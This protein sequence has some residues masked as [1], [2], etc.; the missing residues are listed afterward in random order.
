[1]R[2]FRDARTAVKLLTGFSLVAVLTVVV[3]AVGFSRISS[4]DAS[5]KSM[6]VDSTTAIGYLSDAR[7]NLGDARVQG[8]LAGMTGTPAAVASAQTAWQQDTSGITAAMNSYR[9]TNM[10]G[11]ETQLAAFD[12]AYADYLSNAP[13]LWDLALAHDQA[14]FEKFRRAM[15]QPSAT[16]ATVALTALSMIENTDAKAAADAGHA[17]AATAELLMIAIA[18]ATAL[19]SLTLALL[20]GRMISRPLQATVAVLE[21]VARGELN[22]VVE[23]T[24]NDEIGRMRAALGTALDAIRDT[25]RK[26]GEA[27]QL[28]AASA[29]EFSAVS[30]EM[31]AN[32][33]AVTGS[34]ATASAT[35]LQVSSNVQSVAA[36]TE[37]MSAAIAEIARN[38]SGASTVAQEAVQ[39]AGE[40]TANVGRLAES[41]EKIDDIVK[42]IQAIAEQT[43]LLALNATIEA[44]RAGTAGKG[45]AVVASEVKEL[46]QETATATKNIVVLVEAIQGET[47]SATASMSRISTVIDR[48]NDAQAT[49]AGA[50]EEQTAVTQDI[51]RNVSEASAG[52]DSIAASVQQ[53]AEQADQTTHGAS[54]TQRAAA[55]LAQ[56]AS[57]LRSLV[58]RFTV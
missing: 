41:S 43:N 8:L 33:A 36:G 34:A 56:M 58:S 24:S 35:A 52:A 48:I 42:T 13:K 18:V 16:A 51:S 44:A 12:K 6:Y 49:I 50:V 11:R 37:Q 9:A 3:G 46:A 55:E 26:I 15:V 38:A 54:D 28:L 20:L 39:V 7:T 47:Q 2:R 29:E 57:E 30:T 19:A 1:M 21:R 14:A 27:S 4:L 17:Q 23:V 25:M 40:T 32:S 10:T 22:Q 5:L 53:V 31:A 45:F